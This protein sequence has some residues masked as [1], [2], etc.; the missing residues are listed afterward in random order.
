MAAT[1][2]HMRVMEAATEGL[3]QIHGMVPN[4][5]QDEKFRIMGKN[6][7]GLNNRIGGNKKI[8]RLLDIKEDLD[9]DCLMICKHCLNFKHKDNKNDLKQCFNKK[10][11][12]WHHQHITSMRQNMQE[13]CK[14]GGTGTICFGKSTGFITKIGQ[15]E[16]GLGRWSWIRLRGTDGHATRIVTAYN[17][18]KNR[19]INSRTTYQQQRR[20]FIMKKKDL[21]CPI[22]LFRTHLIKQ[23]TQWRAGG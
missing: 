15:D 7:N 8:G 3:L 18:C 4:T 23:L 10:S 12:V 6:C 17:P 2:E 11:H 9:I 19:N 13:G 1:E 22:I 20:H 14:K 21:I 16:E 5:K